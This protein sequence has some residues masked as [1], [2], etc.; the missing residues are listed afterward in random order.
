MKVAVYD[1][2]MG[3]N[4]GTAILSLEPPRTGRVHVVEMSSYQID[5]AR[6]L[7][8]SV[9]I[10]LNVS[11][12]HI[13]RHGTLE[14]YAAVKARLV[15]G[16]QAQGTSIVGVDDGWCRNIA[17]RLDQAGKRLVRISLEKPPPDAVYV[18]AG[19]IGRGSR[20][21]RS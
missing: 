13:D 21:P 19:A 1:T 3:G 14:H 10:L 9:G 8:P 18:Q 5:V 6:S 20:R 11:E 7:D 4:I 16:V 2:Q 15:A 17:D 12:D